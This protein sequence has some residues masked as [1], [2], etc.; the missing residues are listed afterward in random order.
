MEVVNGKDK[1]KEVL[2]EAANYFMAEEE[3][4]TVDTF[5]VEKQNNCYINKLHDDLFFHIFSYLDLK[6][7]IKMELVCKRW[8]QISLDNWNCIHY[9]NF[10]GFFNTSNRLSGLNDNILVAILKKG[11]NNLKSVDFSASPYVITK[12]S[13]FMIGK[14]CK[15]L[16][17]LNISRTCIQNKTLK[18]LGENL[19]QLQ[20]LKMDRCLNVGEKGFWWMFK[21]LKHLEI[22]SVTESSRLI[23][24][25]LF[26]LHSSLKVV[27]FSNCSRLNDGGICN[28]TKSCPNLS[29]VNL[30]FCISLS[31]Q[32]LVFLSQRCSSIN[33]LNLCGLSKAVT[34]QGFKSLKELKNLVKLNISRN[35]N[36]NDEVIETIGMSCNKIQSLNIESCHPN[37]TCAGINALAYYDSLVELN[38][39]YI[40]DV[41]DTCIS[42]ISFIHKL[43]TLLARCCVKLTNNGV[44]KC[45]LHLQDLMLF[46]LSSCYLIDDYLVQ[47]VIQARCQDIEIILGGTGVTENGAA[48]LCQ[49]LV[50]CKASLI[51]LS[52]GMLR[53]DRD[54]TSAAPFFPES[55]EEDDGDEEEE[56]ELEKIVTIEPS[57]NFNITSPVSNIDEYGEP[58]WV[59]E[60]PQSLTPMLAQNAISIKND[61]VCEELALVQSSN[62]IDSYINQN[63]SIKS[64]SKN[65]TKKESDVEDWDAEVDEHRVWEIPTDSFKNYDVF[66]ED[67]YALMCDDG[68]N[69]LLG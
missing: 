14:V 36:V 68:F 2:K 47:E 16:Q 28:L 54:P 38:I 66:D 32:S 41:C 60:K 17:Q 63:K 9:L 5:K 18:Y 21:G 57:L 61:K 27:D 25:C 29:S 22:L 4:K 39:S 6:T 15:Q 48:A 35:I 50:C 23:G 65:D 62:V 24:K 44:S 53:N 56:K 64:E 11:C 33:N 1:N 31:D 19:L 59:I 42:S 45:L 20:V 13:F 10:K 46:D 26:M 34:H 67:E 40:N 3:K 7:K 58:L 49:K 30:S 37:L 55:D 12:I 52:N 8:R 69:E 43:Q 51:C